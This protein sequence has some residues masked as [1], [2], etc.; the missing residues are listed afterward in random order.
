MRSTAVV[1]VASALCVG[2]GWPLLESGKPEDIDSAFLKP[3][4]QESLLGKSCVFRIKQVH[5]T[6]LAL[7]GPLHYMRL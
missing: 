2:R 5:I 1:C 4:S 3:V 7:Q 6:E